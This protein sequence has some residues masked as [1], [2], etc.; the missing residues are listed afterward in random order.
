[1]IPKLIFLFFSIA[2]CFYGYFYS[3]SWIANLHALPDNETK[4]S[5]EG[6]Y[7]LEIWVGQFFILIGFV[8]LIINISSFVL[9]KRKK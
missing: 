2:L 6:S 5:I 7:F 9:R 3:E 8:T 4:A 1:M